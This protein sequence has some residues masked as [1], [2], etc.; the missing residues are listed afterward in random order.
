M[1]GSPFEAAAPTIFVFNT[2]WAGAILVRM[3][4]G[5]HLQDGLKR[6]SSVFAK[7][8]PAYPFVY[9]FV[10]EEYQHKFDAETQAG[11][12]AALFATLA[13][14]ISC[15]GLL[16]LASYIAERRTREIGIRKVMGATPWRLWR[17]LSR[18]FLL[19][20]LISCVVASPVAYYFAHGWLSKYS[21]RID[22]GP[23]VFLLATALALFIT[24]ITI[25]VQI[26]KV[27][28]V[29]PVKSLRNA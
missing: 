19:L 16:G 27:A 13:I 23:G 4:Q 25:S 5:K 29:N 6:M 28:L 7:Y 17:L 22:I 21:Y 9:H 10:D 26:V 1:M 15:L 18:E 2:G 14:V 20:V 3:S 8:N 24:V 12:L 11:Q